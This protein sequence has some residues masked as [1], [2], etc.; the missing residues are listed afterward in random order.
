MRSEFIK[1]EPINQAT[2]EHQ[3]TAVMVW[4]WERL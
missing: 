1:S 3:L 2:F 4:H